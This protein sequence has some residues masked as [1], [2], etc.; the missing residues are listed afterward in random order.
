MYFSLNKQ[1]KSEVPKQNS[2]LSTSYTCP[3]N[4]K[5]QCVTPEPLVGR[6]ETGAISKLS[7]KLK[8]TVAKETS[9]TDETA[10]KES[11]TAC[12]YARYSCLLFI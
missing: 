2:S 10:I 8:D 12:S 1:S 6:L 5:S 9:A 11:K 4:V 7:F 3:A